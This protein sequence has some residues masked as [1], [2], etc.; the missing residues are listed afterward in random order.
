MFLSTFLSLSF[1]SFYLFY[2]FFVFIEF[3]FVDGH[4]DPIPV[5][6]P[7]ILT[8]NCTGNESSINEC[9]PDSFLMDVGS[10]GDVNVTCSSQLGFAFIVCQRMI[11]LN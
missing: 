1:L 9:D 2:L 4:L 10:G 11:V 3:A 6:R 7:V 8:P 5:G